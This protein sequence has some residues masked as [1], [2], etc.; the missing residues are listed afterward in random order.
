MTEQLDL[1]DW[2]RDHPRQIPRGNGKSILAFNYI[3]LQEEVNEANYKTYA[4]RVKN[5]LLRKENQQ[6]KELLK[7]SACYVYA[8]RNSIHERFAG[9]TP[10]QM[11]ML[12][13]Q[14]DNA[15]GEK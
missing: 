13:N 1:E 9:A 3:R 7:Q 10:E 14:I 4:E 2:L 5:D 6:L 8:A 12:I 11:E 15:I